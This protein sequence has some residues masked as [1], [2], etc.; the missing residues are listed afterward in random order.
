M[1][2]L[3]NIKTRHKKDYFNEY[4]VECLSAAHNEGQ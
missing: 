2:S 1:Y 4:K 3:Y